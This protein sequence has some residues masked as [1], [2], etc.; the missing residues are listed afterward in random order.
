MAT[1]STATTAGTTQLGP[2]L[3]RAGSSNGMTIVKLSA[4]TS[5]QRFSAPIPVRMTSILEMGLR[6]AL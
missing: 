2:R 5:G 3:N 6:G 4:P 1:S